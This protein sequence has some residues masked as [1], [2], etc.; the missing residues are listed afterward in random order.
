MKS[1][2][3]YL[4]EVGNRLDAIQRTTD[5]NRRYSMRRELHG[6]LYRQMGGY[7]FKTI[8]EVRD[9]IDCMKE[10]KPDPSKGTRLKRLQW[11]HTALSKRIEGMEQELQQEKVP[12]S[13]L[14]FLKGPY[15]EVPDQEI[16]PELDLE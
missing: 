16:E 1:E 5:E 4:T 7:G 14:P 15:H 3:E 2:K 10:G 11:Y 13:R 9:A 6:N 12:E 8:D